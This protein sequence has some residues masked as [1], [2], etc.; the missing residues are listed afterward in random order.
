[1]KKLVAL[2]AVAI[3]GLAGA[4]AFSLSDLPAA[5]QGTWVDSNYNANWILGGGDG[6]GVTLKIADAKS[7]KVFY[8]FKESNMEDLEGSVG[9]NGVTITWKSS[10]FG[11]SYK[12]VK[13][14]TDKDWKLTIVRDWDPE[15]Y[16]DQTLEFVGAGVESDVG[17]AV[18]SAVNGA[19]DSAVDSIER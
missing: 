3:I 12:L 9:L 19:L 7:G 8:T 16:E 17:G 13:G 15:P 10:K 6:E 18:D 11:K 5:A 1:M 2:V 14:Y 4:F